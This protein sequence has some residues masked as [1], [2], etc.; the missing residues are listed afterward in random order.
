MKIKQIKKMIKI[1]GYSLLTLIVVLSVLVIN[2]TKPKTDKK[3]KKE[4]KK[5]IYQP[6]IRYLDYKDKVVR[7]IHMQNSLDTTLNTLVFVH[8]SP[9]S[10][11]DFKAYLK[12][13]DLNEKA[14]IIAFDRIG[15]DIENKGKILNSLNEEIEVLDLVLKG[16]DPQKIIIIGYSYGGTL[17]MASPINYKRKIVLAAA[18]RGD[19]EPMFWAMKL[20]EWKITRPIVPKVF[21]AASKEKLRHA[22]ELE[23]FADQ[24]TFSDS[25]VLSI[26]GKKDKIVP[27]DNSVFLEELFDENKFT[28]LPLEKGNHALVW[29]NF[30]LIKKEILKSLE[31]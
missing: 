9:G 5:E 16:L 7:T 24:W 1:I 22:T 27:F 17:V 21:R 31:D 4:F 3:I 8:G 30:E 6:S 11:M 18:V 12:D 28:L 26:H 13:M 2:F 29:T 23:D 20:Y 14:N 15:Y 19:L 25:P 10:S